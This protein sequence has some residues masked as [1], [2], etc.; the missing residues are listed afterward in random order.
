MVNTLQKWIIE[1]GT[2]VIRIEDR[3]RAR[4]LSSLLLILILAIMAERVVGGNTPLW[5]LLILALGYALSRTIYFHLAALGSLLLL[6]APAFW[7]VLTMPEP[8]ATQ[9]WAALIWLVLPILFSS[10]LLTAR[11]TAVIT[12]LYMTGIL[13]L[14]LFNPAITWM[15]LWG[16]LGFV[17]TTGLI[18]LLVMRQRDLIE[19]DRQAELR[20]NQDWLHLAQSAGKM[21]TW[22]WDLV[23]NHIEWSPQTETLF[24][25]TAGAF[26]HTIDM[27]LSLIYP[28][29]RHSLEQAVRFALDQP[30][31]DFVIQHRIL[32]PNEEIRWIEG[33]GKVT[34]DFAGK[35]LRMAGTAI[36][37]TLRRQYESEKEVFFYE[38]QAKNA[39]LQQEINARE[40]SEAALR[41]SEEASRQ[42]QQQ[43][44]AL[45]EVS[46][47]LRQAN[48]FDALCYQAVELGCRR[49][50]FERLGIW[51]FDEH[52]PGMMTGSY[53]ID[54]QGKVRDERDQQLAI[55]LA[56]VFEGDQPSDI[57][58]KA[59]RE[60]VLYD[61]KRKAV[62]EGWNIVAPLWRGDQVIGF[63]SSDNLLEQRPFSQDL[64]EL[65]GLY[66]STLSHLLVQKQEE[67]RTQRRR[68]MLEKLVELSKYV[69][70]VADLRE[71]L[72]RIYQSV[73]GLDFDRVGL[74]LFDET[75]QLLQGTLGTDREGSLREEWHITLPA[76]QISPSTGRPLHITDSVLFTKDYEGTYGPT[77]EN[78]QKSMVGVR[79]HVRVV[80]WV[81]AQPVAVINVDN[82]VSQRPIT[83]EQVEALHLF[84]GYAG[85]A[86]ENARLLEQVQKAEQR[87][88]SIFEN[89]I[90]GIFQVSP[91]GTIVSANPALAHMLGYDSPAQLMS[92]ITNVGDQIY[93]DPARRLELR[94]L[95]TEQGQA[96]NFEFDVKRRDGSRALL[97][98]NV[99]VVIDPKNEFVLY[100]GTVQDITDRKQAEEEREALI[101]ELERRNAELERFTYTVS[102]DL[103]SP[104]ITIQGFLGFIEKDAL[105]RNTDRLKADIERITEA[106]E[107]MR[108]LL[109]ELLEL[110]RVG[111]LVNPSENVAFAELV[112]EAQALVSGQ[113]MQREVEVMV[114]ADLP[115]V[116]V[117]RRRL[118]EVLQNLLDNAAKF[119]GDQTAPRIEVGA[120]IQD[121]ET[122]FF[123]RDNGVGI[124]AAYQE[125]VFGLFERLDQSVD[126][127]GIGLA[128]VKRIVEVHNGRIWVESAGA[129]QGTTFY[130]TLPLA[131]AAATGAA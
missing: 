87:Y 126:G 102:H 38:L 85:L 1:P 72:L 119:M 41:Q 67:E 51:F 107:R 46:I 27:Y 131:E 82:L 109:D 112:E 99:K 26:D 106:T 93:M 4:L 52:R 84:A 120:E 2:G 78:F 91:E 59:W 47:E 88:R 9:I 5:L 130:F 113:L 103:K 17:A 97:S 16:A 70:Q 63:I 65:L 53:G 76:G 42:F 114:A 48:S 104:L 40:Q 71:C 74:F 105:A 54:E 69:T 121:A 45:Q 122:V 36:D 111:R 98:Q 23:S 128:L 116:F 30:E 34:C 35:P 117:D 6:G 101:Q 28:V 81:G 58:M 127:T 44:I 62:G 18:V 57:K 37:I 79:Q 100:E 124:E 10:A 56:E 60:N 12:G 29:D 86:I 61:D 13:L 15:M 73:R 77:S 50:W 96:T 66:A 115:A 92:L 24:G 129:G 68:E 90:E 55:T 80:S 8:T 75:N 25:L 21:G 110:S 89:A 7:I 64:L 39:A 125:T 49:L 94:R 32:L 3:R 95:L 123:V 19:R 14:P 33:R 83:D 31:S 108:R 20:A 11:E 43:L 118:V 22:N